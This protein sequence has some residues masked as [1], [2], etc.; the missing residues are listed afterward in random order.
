MGILVNNKK[1][2]ITKLK[3]RNLKSN[4]APS[5]IVNK[6]NFMEKIK[7]GESNSTVTLDTENNMATI[8]TNVRASGVSISFADGSSLAGK[9]IMVEGYLYGGRNPSIKTSGYMKS[10]TYDILVN[11]EKY[12]K[13]RFQTVDNHNSLYLAIVDGQMYGVTSTLNITNVT[14]FTNHLDDPRMNIQN[15]TDITVNQDVIIPD[16]MELPI[17]V[18]ANTGSAEGMTFFSRNE[19]IISF[20]NQ[21]KKIISHDTEGNVEIYCINKYG[22]GRRLTFE[23]TK[24]VNIKM[25]KERNYILNNE[26]LPIEIMITPK[27]FKDDI[28]LSSSDNLEATFTSLKGIKAGDAEVSISYEPKQIQKVYNFKIIDSELNNVQFMKKQNLSEGERY[29][30]SCYFFE[31]DGGEATYEIMTYENYLASLPDDVKTVNFGVETV[32]TP[33]DEYGNHTLDNGLVAKYIVPEDNIVKVEQWGCIGDGKYDNTEAL[34][35][36]F[37]LTKTGTIEFGKDK[38]YVLYSRKYNIAYYQPEKYISANNQS[39]YKNCSNHQ[40]AATACSYITSGVY[41][42]KPLMFNINNVTLNGN[43]CTITIPENEFTAGTNE[44]GIFEFCGDVDGLEIKNFTFNQNGLSSNYYLDDNCK[45]Q[46]QPTRAHTIFFGDNCNHKWN[47]VNIHHNKFYECGTNVNVSD[48]G[49]DFILV[50]NPLESSNVF[51]ED[52]EFYDWGRWVYSVDLGGNGERFYNYKFNRNICIQTDNNYHRIGNDGKTG[53]YRGLGWIDFEARKCFTGIECCDNIVRGLTGWAI[54]GNG[55]MTNNVLVKNNTFERIGRSYRSAYPY[56]FEWYSCH[57]KDAVFENNTG[58]YGKFGASIVDSSFINNSCGGL[59]LNNCY[60]H[61]LI[62]GVDSTDTSYFNNL[63]NIPSYEGM[64]A[65]NCKIEIKNSILKPNIIMNDPYNPDKFDNYELIMEN[66]FIGAARG[67][68]I[69]VMGLK[70]GFE[71]DVEQFSLESSP[72]FYGATLKDGSI[73]YSTAVNGIFPARLI[74]KEGAI[75]TNGL[76]KVGRREQYYDEFRYVNLK[77]KKAIRCTKEGCLVAYNH[78]FFPFTANKSYSQRKFIFTDE[79]IYLCYK[80]G[81]TG[82]TPPTHT[83]GYEVNGTAG[84]QYYAPIAQYEYLSEIEQIPISDYT[85]GGRLASK[86]DKEINKDLGQNFSISIEPYPINYNTNNDTTFVLTDENNISKYNLGYMSDHYFY[87]CSEGSFKFEA[88][89][90]TNNAS[91]GEFTV[92]IN[93]YTDR[94]EVTRQLIF[95]IDRNSVIGAN[96]IITNNIDNDYNLYLVSENVLKDEN[97]SFVFNGQGSY[98]KFSKN[99]LN[100]FL[101]VRQ[102]FFAEICYT[103]DHTQNL[104]NLITDDPNVEGYNKYLQINPASRKILISGKNTQNVET[105]LLNKNNVSGINWWGDTWA[106]SFSNGAQR[107][108]SAVNFNIQE[109]TT[110]LYLCFDANIIVHEVKIFTDIKANEILQD[111]FALYNKH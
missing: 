22:I 91:S 109:D 104:T 57:I 19:N 88:K 20:D 71:I 12:F 23:V 86:L 1:K 7:F 18:I 110:D 40:Y 92:N 26:S 15:S 48:S 29:N 61:I 107:G 75:I 73:G 108:N 34:I 10:R 74:F 62:D 51:I 97:G 72:T 31:G 95:N 46:N 99:I 2:L 94:E 82:D 87:P 37:S 78:M 42:G 52:N 67:S 105:N 69:D 4:I 65:T 76:N 100:E 8:T 93:N 56:N 96:N 9:D 84:L 27:Y 58:V 101:Q 30:T 80:A 33:V 79:H 54:N 41:R 111:F 32:S 14:V 68:I 49:G 43:N 17:S 55:K 90:Q 89:S 59:T 53:S 24:E 64:N 6:N 39:K 28:K 70:N 44:F 16:N 5:T 35:H 77:D 21:R 25:V 63:G 103:L 36:L 60:G 13:I 3:N 47:N 11:D 83:S 81:T 45:R 102:V 38:E 98:M 85:I 50:V 66:N 106:A